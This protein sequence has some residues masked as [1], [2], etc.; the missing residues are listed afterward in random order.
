MCVL[1]MKWI[2]AIIIAYGSWDLL[3][4]LRRLVPPKKTVPQFDLDF[5]VHI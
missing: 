4:D 5:D 1:E 3:R 2:V